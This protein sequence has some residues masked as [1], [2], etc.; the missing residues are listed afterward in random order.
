[1]KYYYIVCRSVTYAQKTVKTLET[2]GIS[3][4]MYRTPKAM[5]LEGCSYCVKI[6]EARLT[7]AIKL[8]SSK[9]LQ[10]LRVFARFDDGS[11]Y[12]ET[13]TAG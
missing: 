10:P 8:L 5:A 3:A 6:T 2:S 4:V 12:E 9:S 1:M 11:F 7:E 13:V